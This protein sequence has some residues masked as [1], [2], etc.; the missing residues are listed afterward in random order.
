MTLPTALYGLCLVNVTGAP[1]TGA[2]TLGSAVT[3][4]KD[5]TGIPNS[6]QVYYAA[7]DGINTEVSIGT[8][9]GTGTSLS[10]GSTGNITSTN[11]NNLVNFASSG[12]TVAVVLGDGL[13]MEMINDITSLMNSRT[14]DEANIS[15]LQSSRTTDESNISTLQSQVSTLQGQVATIDGGSF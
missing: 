10:R 5:F 7:T 9:S 4:Y 12:V 6:T 13:I 14:T 15:S 1:G 11:S 3:G 8:V 2:F